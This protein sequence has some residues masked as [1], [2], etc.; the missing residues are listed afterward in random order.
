MRQVKRLPLP[1]ETSAYLRRRQSRVDKLRQRGGFNAEREWKSARRS[2]HLKEVQRVLL[3]MSGERE[4]CMYCLDS[5]GTDIEHYW[6][7]TPYPDKMFV[8]PNLLSCCTEGNA[9]G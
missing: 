3:R 1:Q 5:H 9:A 4:R 2:R 6:P 8:W 7:K